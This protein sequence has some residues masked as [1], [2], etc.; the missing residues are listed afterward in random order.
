MPD[1]L[2][3]HRAGRP[4]LFQDSGSAS[5]QRIVLPQI[6]RRHRHLG[7]HLRRQRRTQ[8][9]PHRTQA[10][11]LRRAEHLLQGCCHGRLALLGRQVQKLHIVLVGALGVLGLQAVVG[12]AKR[13]RRIQVLPEG[14]AGKRARFTH[15]PA[16][17][18]T[19]V[20]GVLVLAT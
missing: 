12:A 6:H 4:R 15:Q 8:Q 19:V 14:V 7:H 9:R 11:R 1:L 20:D 10:Q 18:V 5:Q 2:G 17:D 16:N 13:R 3:F